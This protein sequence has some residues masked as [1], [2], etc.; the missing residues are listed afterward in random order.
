M[1]LIYE[2]YYSP[3]HLVQF[4]LY[5]IV[6]LRNKHIFHCSKDRRIDY[7]DKQINVHTGR[8]SYYLHKLR[9]RFL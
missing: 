6:Y 3:I 4:L 8:H 9:N 1:Y 2:A 7:Y 5:P